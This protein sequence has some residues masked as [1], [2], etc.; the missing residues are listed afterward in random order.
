MTFIDTHC[1]LDIDLFFR[2]HP[3]HLERARA[4]GVSA[5]VLPGVIRAG[6]DRLIALCR[7]ESDLF[8][9]PGL[10]PMYLSHHYARHLEELQSLASSGR[11]TALGEIGLDYFVD[12]DRKAQQQLF[13]AQLDIAEGARLPLLLHVR[14]AHDQVTATLRRRR[15]THGGIVHAYNGSYQQA[16]RYID[17]GRALGIGG[18]VTYPR[19][20]KI[21]R[22]AGQLPFHALVLES[23]APDIPPILHRGE[24]NLPEY[25]PQVAFALAELRGVA[26]DEI[27]A[28]TSENAARI[29]GLYC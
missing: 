3:L 23:D 28:T 21:R 29:L 27:A 2:H 4:A 9:A 13:E 18:N 16:C 19:A 12:V 25:L 20:R 24:V 8:A 14:K 15:F 7:D 22:V 17:L 6:W 10:H 26:V 11:L 1:H 5:M